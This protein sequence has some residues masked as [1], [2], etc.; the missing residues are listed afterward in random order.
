MR[1]A[2]LEAVQH[3]NV[4]EGLSHKPRF[5]RCQVYFEQGGS[6]CPVGG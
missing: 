5:R 4:V 2:L 3:R 6:S 1:K